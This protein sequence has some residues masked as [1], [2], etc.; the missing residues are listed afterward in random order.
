MEAEGSE[1]T[2]SLGER[3]T[4]NQTVREGQMHREAMGPKLKP[5][6]SFFFSTSPYVSRATNP[7]DC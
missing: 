5:F 6:E 2:E 7:L 3:L 1:H 4:S